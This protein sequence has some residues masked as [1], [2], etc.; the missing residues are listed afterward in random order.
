MPAARRRALPRTGRP[1]ETIETIMAEG[2]EPSPEELDAMAAFTGWGSFGQQLFQG[3]WDNPKP[4]KGWEAESE[5]L[6][7][8]LGQEAWEDAQNSIINAHYTD[9]PTVMAMWDMVRRMG[10]KGGRVLEP[11]MGV[12]NFFGLMPPDIAANSNLTGIELDRTTGAIAKALY[13]KANIRVMATKNR[14][15][16]MASMTW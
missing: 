15:R 10:F 16:R 9:P 6:R 7:D 11:S 1:I 5:W 3:T 2:R 8:A 13:P 4:M 14:S 12:G